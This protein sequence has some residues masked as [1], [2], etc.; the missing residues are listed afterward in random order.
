MP[1]SVR[2]RGV[3][4]GTSDLDQFDH[5][6]GVVC[7]R[8]FPGA[9]YELVQDVFRLYADAAAGAVEGNP[10][11]EMLS[12]YFRARD[13]L[14]LELFDATGVMIGT[15]T[16]D[17]SDYSREAG[18]EAYEVIVHLDAPDAWNPAG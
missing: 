7:G 16:I 11:E 15:S 13:A 3:E 10:D 4:I 14:G 18:T 2:I 9:G 17:I 1:F 5:G 12:R 6:S 8:F